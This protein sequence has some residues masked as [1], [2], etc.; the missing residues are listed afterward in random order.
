MAQL[1]MSQE[2]EGS[3]G[4]SAEEAPRQRPNISKV[5]PS[6]LLARLQNFLPQMELANSNL[7]NG[8]MA[9]GGS[10]A[11]RDTAQ[12]SCDPVIMTVRE[13]G[14]ASNDVNESSEPEAPHVEMVSCGVPSPPLSIG[15][16]RECYFSAESFVWGFGREKSGRARD[17]RKHPNTWGTSCPGRQGGSSEQAMHRRD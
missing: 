5:E 6:A 15:S 7:P 2:Q 4:V 11:S 17:R 10:T 12:A 8:E 1:Q 13:D 3:G 16:E 14:D 9:E